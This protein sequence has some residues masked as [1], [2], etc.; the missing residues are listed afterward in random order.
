MTSTL[1]SVW[2][3]AAARLGVATH[4]GWFPVRLLTAVRTLRRLP[5]PVYAVATS[6]REHT[7]GRAHMATTDTEV[8]LATQTDQIEEVQIRTVTPANADETTADMLESLARSSIESAEQPVSHG[9][10]VR[11]I[12]AYRHRWVPTVVPVDDRPRGFQAV[13]DGGGTVLLGYLDGHVVV[14]HLRGAG[15]EQLALHRVRSAR[16]LVRIG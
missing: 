8:A 3:H 13:H 6:H 15:F 14:V 11:R 2:Q 4:G 1:R 12:S 9:E 10:F 16:S 5:V 7:I